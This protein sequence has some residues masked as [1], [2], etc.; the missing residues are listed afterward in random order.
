[1]PPLPSQKGTTKKGRDVRHSRSRNTT[2]STVGAL[3]GGDSLTPFLGLPI[4]TLQATEDITTYHGNTIP[5]SKDLDALLDRLKR[6][7]QIV[8]ARGSVCDKGMRLLA[9]IRKDRLQEIETERREI[10]TERREE[11]NKER[12]KRDVAEEEERERIKA[13]KLK[14]RKNMNSSK[15]RQPTHGAH[16]FTNLDDKKR[17]AAS[18]VADRKVTVKIMR[19]SISSSS[20]LSP[21]APIT[22]VAID[23]QSKEEGKE[24]NDSSSDEH[25]P[26]PAPTVMN[27]QTFGD[28]P[29][30]F[31]DDTV[32]EIQEVKEGMTRDQLKEIYSVAY[33][34]ENSLEDLIAGTPPD[35]DFSNAKPANQVQ[36]NNFATY[37]EPYFRPFG[38]Q[39]T[40]FLRERGDRVTPFI[41]PSRGKRHYTEIWAEEDGTLT[42]DASHQ[43]RE[44]L[45]LNQPRG[46]MDCMN[47]DVAE[48]DAISTGPIL[49][50]LLASLRS[51]HRTASIETSNGYSNGDFHMEGYNDL[52]DNHGAL[53]DSNSQAPA[54][55]M[56]ESNT[57]AW[58]KASYPILD[59]SQIDERLKLE[60]RHIGFMPLEG[61]PDYDTHNDDDVA[62]RLR[63]LQAKLKQTVIMNGARKARLQELVKEKMA[64]QEFSSILEDLDSQVQA[65]YLKRTRTLGKTKKAKRPGGVGG[66]SHIATG[67]IGTGMA[68][69]GIG[70]LTK[71]LLERRRKWIDT[72]GG[73]L[74]PEATK[75]RRVQDPGSS[76]FE[77]ET[78]VEYL[79]KEEMGLEEEGEENE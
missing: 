27:L 7:V 36:A 47:D 5:S 72:I 38:D 40:A 73:V 33:F 41:T 32:Y 67:S 8:E 6:L 48:S 42:S 75:V 11:E 55:Q 58:K 52:S 65:A 53:T 74:D 19:D 1:M 17:H 61:E 14:R 28:D 44:K 12:F 79:R 4:Q 37:L 9:Q 22:P 31:P 29:S 63:F 76:I 24:D 23:I 54:T 46:S 50:R 56:P 13:N 66:G 71:T 3:S 35:K 34:P 57:E 64:H 51:E 26:S 60:L 30:T 43:S 62:V 49:S 10:E 18:P 20:S 45:P 59:Y 69:P 15:E 70:D 2:P 78:L 25:R 68:R 77:K 21:P 16:S 39:D